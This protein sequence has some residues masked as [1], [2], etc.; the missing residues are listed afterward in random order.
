VAHAWL[1]EIGPATDEYFGS[2]EKLASQ[3]TLCRATT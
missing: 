1:A 3:V 2:H